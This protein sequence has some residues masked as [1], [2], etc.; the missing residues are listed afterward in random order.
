MSADLEQ[1][2]EDAAKRPSRQV[3][4]ADLV[5]RADRRTRT[6]RVLLSVVAV[7]ALAAG[8]F[9]VQQTLTD[10]GPPEIVDQP[11]TPDEPDEAT[12]V[13]PELA[14]L[15]APGAR[16]AVAG[17]GSVWIAANYPPQ[18]QGPPPVVRAS[19]DA[20]E[21]EAVIE[22][23]S[24]MRWLAVT[25]GYVW[26]AAN[27]D[28]AQRDNLLVRIDPD[29]N[30]ADPP[31]NLGEFQV[32][33]MLVD[34]HGDLLLLQ[35]GPGDRPEVMRVDGTTGDPMARWQ[36]N[37]VETV[38]AA[39]YFDGRLAVTDLQGRLAVF[40][41]ETLSDGGQGS[42]LQ[43]DLLVD[44]LPERAR[45]VAPTSS[46]IWSVHVDP[47]RAVRT[48]WEADTLT[49]VDLP[50]EPADVTTLVRSA[51]TAQQRAATAHVALTGGDVIAVD[52]S[53]GAEP[54]AS[55]DGPLGHLLR[56]GNNL[57][58]FGD[59]LHVIQLDG[60]STAAPTALESL[61]AMPREGIAV[62]V[63]GN[64]E[65]IGLDGD[66][67]TVLPGRLGSDNSPVT[68]RLRTPTNLIGLTD[69][70]RGRV[71]LA[72]DTG[73]W[74]PADLEVPLRAGFRVVYDADADPSE[75][76][77]LHRGDTVLAAW[78]ETVDWWLTPDHRVVSWETCEA[79]GCVHRFLDTDSMDDPQDMEPGC[80]VGHV[81]GDFGVTQICED[82]RRI[83][84][85]PPSPEA[86]DRETFTV[87]DGTDGQ[88]AQAVAVYR[89]GIVRVDHA[90][91]EIS[92]PMR[93]DDQGGLIRLLGDDP[94][95][96]PSAVPLGV[97]SDGQVV[98]HYNSAACDATDQSPGVYLHDPD[99]GNQQLIYEGHLQTGQ[100]QMW[101]Q[102]AVGMTPEPDGGDTGTSPAGQPTCLED[103][104]GQAGPETVLVYFGCGHGSDPLLA[105]TRATPDDGLLQRLAYVVSAHIDNECWPIDPLGRCTFQDDL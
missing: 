69:T 62:E 43:P 32:A 89:G 39:T 87:P 77:E 14:A 46:G 72:P 45:A 96:N 50:G 55:A 25:G 61:P 49:T 20:S 11:T 60:D 16:D 103:T 54:I 79:A 85:V 35:G 86:D 98:L 48:S 1:A 15:A 71:W 5:R 34:G 7:L 42:S 27:A 58:L 70:D 102:N 23:D 73:A 92:E 95:A 80:H 22:M 8:G 101:T 40:T 29:T 41:D 26:A 2:L 78:P 74:Q 44:D 65:L 28:G 30:Q 99:T 4:A 10:P 51:R 82:G 38:S 12:G 97:T 47:H 94:R 33:E 104:H 90:S 53:G 76:L 67:R 100:A 37:G 88:P 31:I 105:T 59:S 75:R 21:V 19:A 24:P 83:V 9:A 17:F 52:P 81:L 36:L 3:D 93:L 63:D 91:C 56:D 57:W 68:D 66:V 64:V 13:D 84:R 6:T 18:P